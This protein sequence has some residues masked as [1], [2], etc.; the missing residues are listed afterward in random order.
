[1]N[2]MIKGRKGVALISSI[3][4]ISILLVSTAPVIPEVLKARL[5]S[6]NS[7]STENSQP[8]LTQPALS[9]SQDNP[10]KNINNKE[11]IQNFITGKIASRVVKNENIDKEVIN[12]KEKIASDSS[13][14]SDEILSVSNE[15]KIN[16]NSEENKD[17]KNPACFGGCEAKNYESD[18][19][20]G[21]T[22][23]CSGSYEECLDYKTKSTVYVYAAGSGQLV[24]QETDSCYST[25]ILYE[26]YLA[27]SWYG[28]DEIKF[29]SKNCND[30]DSYGGWEYECY[31]D[32]V[33]QHRRFYN[34]GCS[35][36]EC[37]ELNRNYVDETVL[38]EIGDG[39]FCG[40]KADHCGGCERNGWD[41]DFDSECK[42]GLNCASVIGSTI[43]YGFECGCCNPATSTKPAEKWDATLH[44]CYE[45][46]TNE[47]TSGAKRC[48]GNSVQTC[49][50]HDSDGCTE[51]GGDTSCGS[52]SCGSWGSPYCK[53]NDVYHSRT[54]HDRGCSN[55]ACSD[56][57]YTEEALVQDCGT[58]TC[59]GGVCQGTCT[60]ECSSGQTRCS[61]D[62]KQTCGNYDSD[63]CL[64]W[65]SSTSGSGNDNCN[66]C[67]CTC[68][69]YGKTSEAGY[70]SDG[71]DN[72]CDGKTDCTDSDCVADPNC[73]GQCTSGLCCDG[74]NFRPSS[75][76][77][78]Q[79]T[80][81]S[82]YWGIGC[83]ADVAVA[84]K[85]QYC[86]GSSSAC[87]GSK[88]YGSWAQ[89]L[90]CT[91][92][93][94]CN[95]WDE[96]VPGTCISCGN[97]HGTTPPGDASYCSVNCKCNEGEGD[98]DSD[99]ECNTGLTCVSSSGTDYCER[100]I[101]PTCTDY[102]GGKDY[103]K[104]S[105]VLI[106]NPDG[107]EKWY[108]DACTGDGKSVYENYCK[109]ASTWAMET[110]TCPNGCSNGACIA[111]TQTCYD[112]DGGKDYY[113][114]SSVLITEASGTQHWYNDQCYDSTKVME[115]YCDGNNDAIDVYA[116][117]NGCSDGKCITT[118][119]TCKDYDD[120]LNFYVKSSVL[121]KR[122][123]GSQN[124]YNDACTGDGKSVYENYCSGNEWKMSTYACPVG[125]SDGKCIMPSGT[126]CID[127]DNGPN[128]YIKSSVLM[129]FP[130]GIQRWYTDY[131]I[132]SKNVRDMMCGNNILKLAPLTCPDGSTCSDG[133][134]VV[135]QGT[136]CKDY[137][138]GKNYNTKSSVLM[139]FPDGTEKWYNDACTGDGK[140]VYENYCK[141]AS[142]W[143]METYT[144]SGS[145]SDG[146]CTVTQCPSS[147]C[148]DYCGGFFYPPTHRFYDLNPT[149][150]GFW[151][152]DTFCAYSSYE[153]CP[154][155][156]SN[157]VCF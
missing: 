18:E 114:K 62:Y 100:S 20:P 124:W 17:T 21:G 154:N 97:C 68:G 150:Y 52:D 30:Y 72:D 107:S 35:S 137:D 37:I 102:D 142:T 16:L 157:G 25:S 49:S 36:G 75:Y 46:C 51:W 8:A 94:R 139:R 153:D 133:K 108:N 126:T 111:G 12:S 5:D 155:G 55:S 141:D 54:C 85:T 66:D 136:I 86:S 7:A 148:G 53:N 131:C 123:D 87:D 104:K 92:T 71:K 129:N 81:Y 29:Q 65:P 48:S 33:I 50:D 101:T 31:A 103:Y 40:V 10:L 60:N 121:I 57:P 84:T 26:R 39:D 128:P 34:Y 79:G 47:C 96:N 106:K 38:S 63:S 58:A 15:Q 24:D 74:G 70:C 6:I 19:G 67:S 140:S 117:P 89:Y 44:K 61:G 134:C 149:G 83:T 3:L 147:V 143:A 41:C 109:D 125:C 2:K 99:S 11:E 78:Y 28:T 59:S 151:C 130:G 32:R 119:Q 112:Y 95:V 138:N 69:N 115:N 80:A 144:C 156:C 152:G 45:I 27:C 88:S 9:A 105:S 43:C 77:C 116:C 42:S 127:Y 145:C 23:C 118:T 110:Y 120:G 82:C 14:S 91:S 135:P 122:L 56:N 13:E 64:E 113:K 1:M 132:D 76:V 98:C 73:Q 90:E 93:E 146:A 4:I 22:H